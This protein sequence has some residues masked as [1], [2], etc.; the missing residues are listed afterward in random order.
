[1]LTFILFIAALVVFIVGIFIIFTGDFGLPGLAA[2]LFIMLLAALVGYSAFSWGPQYEV[3][4]QG[5]AG[6]AELSRAEQNRQIKVKEAQ[7]K[8]DSSKLE[9]AA[10]I[11][12]A[13]GASEANKIM[14]DSLGGPDRYLR[15]RW[16]MM[17]ENN[18]KG[19]LNREIIYVPADGNLPMTEAGRAVQPP[20][21]VR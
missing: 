2:G 13:K 16:I 21:P 10:E 20:A 3:W 17:L 12:R 15:W 18:E 1:M 14:V 19:G 11:E 9:A 8:L 6:Q 7:A 4:Q 5:M